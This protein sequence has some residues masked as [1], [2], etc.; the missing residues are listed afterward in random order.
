VTTT[1]WAHIE[2]AGADDCWW[3]RGATTLDDEPMYTWT[4]PGVG[5]FVM[6]ARSHLWWLTVGERPAQRPTTSCM[7]PACMNPAHIPGLGDTLEQAFNPQPDMVPT[8]R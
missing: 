5:Q 8:T 7:N 3:W 6:D 1:L 2:I 4:E